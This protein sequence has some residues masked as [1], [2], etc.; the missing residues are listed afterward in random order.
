MGEIESSLEQM[1]ER[2]QTAEKLYESLLYLNQSHNVPMNEIL[3]YIL[4][5]GIKITHS[6]IGHLYFYNE[7]TKMLTKYAWSEE[8]RQA[9]KVLH[10]ETTYELDKIGLCGEAIRQ[11]KA[12]IVNDYL[13]NVD[14]KGTPPGHM[15]LI[16]HMSIPAII[17]GR[18]IALIGVANKEKEYDDYDIRNLTLL[19]GLGL[20]KNAHHE[21]VKNYAESENRFKGTFEQAGVG[22]CYVSL[23]G[24]FLKVNQKL[25]DT[26]GF[27]NDEL[28]KRNIKQLTCSEDLFNDLKL[29]KDVLN[30]SSKSTSYERR[31]VKPDRSIVWIYITLSLVKDN[32]G[33]DV[34]LFTSQDITDRKQAEDKLS[35]TQA[36]L[37]AALDNSQAGIAIADAPDGRLRYINEA[38]LSFGYSH[39]ARGAHHINLTKH[40]LDFNMIHEDGTPLKYNERP[41]VRA[42][43]YGETCSKEFLFRYGNVEDRIV[44][45]NAAPV[46]DKTGRIIAGISIFLDISERKRIEKSLWLAK[47]EAEKANVAK[48][49]FLANM[50]HE[51]R[52]PMTGIM[53]MTDLTLMTELTDE[54][55][56][57]L[58]IVKSSTKS[59][60]CVLNDILDYSKI[61]AGKMYLENIGFRLSGVIN[62]VVAL[63]SVVAQQ[64]RLNI[65]AKIDGKIPDILSGDSFRLRQVLSNLIGNAVKFTASGEIDVMITCQ[66][67]DANEIKLKFSVHDTGIGIAEDKLEILFKSF[68]QVDDSNTRQFGGTGL[69]LA[70]CKKLTELM[71]G[72]IGV[73]SEVGRGSQFYFTAVF[74]LHK[75]QTFQRNDD[76]SKLS[77]KEQAKKKVLLVEDDEVSQNMVKIVL[78][79]KGLGVHMVGNG[80][81]AVDM[82]TQHKF[83]L[84]IMDIN[85]PYMDGYSAVNLIR[86]GERKTGLHIPIIALTA[87]ALKGEREK[88]LAIGMDDYLSKPVDIG[89][90]N[91]IID[92]WL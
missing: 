58:E 39:D 70:I 62:E 80:Q 26:I 33:Q 63:F 66:H 57:Y 73:E 42:V 4:E 90:L 36:I 3:D 92:K 20:K 41:L 69:G 31:Y 38:G 65:S 56:Q 22:I 48:S 67:V 72:E 78:L 10:C 25:C 8:T 29:V 6:K 45:I 53:G 30:G 15:P 21:A 1:E 91:F 23:T 9:C 32:E 16:R 82:A 88:C 19:I 46:R 87:Y 77:L 76:R 54:Q 83:D 52:T 28:L 44:W 89:Q 40:F 75:D 71:K 11:R 17:N 85:M 61:E 27:S 24:D 50:S 5:M 81:E 59:L 47:E 84:I 2:L 37:E 12:I 79:K 51:I 49:Q 43:L 13:Q 68:S 7:D 34:Y 74:G 18:I 35:Q 64:K 60:L 55:R 86:E 14:K